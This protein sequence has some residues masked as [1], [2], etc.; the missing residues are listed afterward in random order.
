MRKLIL[1]TAAV[2]ALGLSGLAVSST[3]VSAG[4]TDV[5]DYTGRCW[6]SWRWNRWVCGYGGGY[7][8]GWGHGHWGHGHGGWGH[9]HGRRGGW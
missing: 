2:A 6:W 1:A 8:G 7:G 9:G 3:P 5:S 4:T